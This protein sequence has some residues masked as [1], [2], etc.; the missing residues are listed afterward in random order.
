[1]KTL[2]FYVSCYYYI[3][4]SWLFDVLGIMLVQF[5]QK[6]RSLEVKTPRFYLN[7]MGI[8]ALVVLYFLPERF[9]SSNLNEYSYCLHKQ[10]IGIDCP[11]C[12]FTRAAYYWLHLDFKSALILNCSVLFIYPV[13]LSEILYQLL[14]TRWL[15]KTRFVVYSCFCISLLFLYLVRIFNH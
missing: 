10:L 6:F 1:M 8:G 7:L 14:Q 12:G 5:Q 4:I 9:F 3:V 11:G 2:V 13:L 15:K